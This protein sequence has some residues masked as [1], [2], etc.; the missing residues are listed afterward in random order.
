MC[1]NVE[2]MCTNVEWP[3]TNVEQ[4]CTCVFCSECHVLYVCRTRQKE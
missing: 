2:W 1:T 3:S 4:L